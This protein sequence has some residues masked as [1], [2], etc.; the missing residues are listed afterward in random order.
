MQKPSARSVTYS[1]FPKIKRNTTTA[2][3]FTLGRVNTF[4]ELREPTSDHIFLREIEKKIEEQRKD[5]DERNIAIKSLLEHF[6]SIAS[7][8]RDEKNR[9]IEFRQQ[10]MELAK[11]NQQLKRYIED[12][13]AASDR[14]AKTKTPRL[15]Q[16]V[17]SDDYETIWREN[18]RLKETIKKN[19][20]DL[21]GRDREISSLSYQIG[22]LKGII[23]GLEK[24]SSDL[25]VEINIG[26]SNKRKLEE[27]IAGCRAQ[28]ESFTEQ[29]IDRISQI[30]LLNEKLQKHEEDKRR[31]IE[32]IEVKENEIMKL[33]TWSST[34]SANHKELLENKTR[35]NSVLSQVAIGANDNL[36]TIIEKF[37]KSLNAAN[38]KIGMMERE[39][40]QL[41]FKINK[42]STARKELLVSIEEFRR[43]NQ[44]DVL[45]YEKLIQQHET[46]KKMKE[47]EIKELNETVQR[48]E[49]QK[50][51]YLDDLGKLELEIYNEKHMGTQLNV[52]YESALFEIQK[53]QSTIELKNDE[54]E[55][56]LRKIEEFHEFKIKHS[57]VQKEVKA[58]RE[59]NSRLEKMNDALNAKYLQE[60]EVWFKEE[61]SLHQKLQGVQEEL[62][63]EKTFNAIHL[64]EVIKL[65]RALSSLDFKSNK[66]GL[67]EEEK[68]LKAKIA[69]LEMDIAEEK[70][71]IAKLQKNIAYSNLQLIEKQKLIVELEIQLETQT[72]T[73]TDPNFINMSE[74]AQVL[75]EREAAVSN[76][77]QKNFYAL[78]AFENGMT[79][80]VCLSCLDSPILIVPCGHAV[81]NKCLNVVNPTCPQCN[82]RILGQYRIEWLD[83]LL[84]KIAFQRQVLESMK[85][86]LEK[87][88]F[89]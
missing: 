23:I 35:E 42:G 66:E 7:T 36:L 89:V 76:E 40:V 82:H 55:R 84:D 49:T 11:E 48:V 62:N 39:S 51:S 63:N 38:E 37:T 88:Q 30:D 25:N 24:H 9:N 14:N 47:I 33:K 56:H 65:K 44:N 73:L 58:V 13:N 45:K 41:K 74:K 86:L 72:R 80:I 19:E 78:E 1:S 68:K 10:N 12:K 60:K 54:I 17:N 15:Q 50:R 57:I 70:E 85:A 81:C 77:L 16:Y 69:T 4:S 31:L 18:D 3:G 20:K 52:K 43:S 6:K 8:C 26:K 75:K 71:M 21:E 67:I 59:E 34:L 5:L 22:N 46:N 83:Q 32:D 53:L 79:C 28:M 61:A 2:A 29:L 27:E 64:Q 87:Q